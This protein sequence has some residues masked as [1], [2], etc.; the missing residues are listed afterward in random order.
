MHGREVHIGEVE[1][2]TRG[3]VVELIGDGGGEHYVEPGQI[4]HH[5][6]QTKIDILRIGRKHHQR[7]TFQGQNVTHNLT[8]SAVHPQTGRSGQSI[9]KEKGY[10]DIAEEG[11]VRTVGL[12]DVGDVEGRIVEVVAEREIGGDKNGREDCVYDGFGER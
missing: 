1:V 3:C 7:K 8:I 2:V 6:S 10:N 11:E 9:Q 4:D 5:K 12:V